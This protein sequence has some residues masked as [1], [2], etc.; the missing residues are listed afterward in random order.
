M[1][2]GETVALAAAG[3]R[4][5]HDV[6]PGAVLAH[7]VPVDGHQVADPMA[8]VARQVESLEEYLRQDHRRTEID[9]RD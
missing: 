4:A 5:L 6:Y 3:G 7:E 9:V 8:E 1:V 2:A